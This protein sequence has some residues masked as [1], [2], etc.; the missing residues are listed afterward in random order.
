MVT[1]P[2]A[3][4]VS[5]PWRLTSPTPTSSLDQ[6]AVVPGIRSRPP[7]RFCANRFSCTGA[8]IFMTPSPGFITSAVMSLRIGGPFH[9]HWTVVAWYGDAS[10]AYSRHA[11]QETRRVPE[12][13]PSQVA[14]GQ[15]GDN[16]SNGGGAGEQRRPRLPCRRGGR[17]DVREA[18]TDFVVPSRPRQEKREE[19]QQEERDDQEEHEQTLVTWCTG[20]A[21][22]VGSGDD[23]VV[24]RG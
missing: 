15:V 18:G 13:G 19:K 23:R 7:L 3:R 6:V 21:A 2:G 22:W 12:C 17:G 4:G 24:Q 5:R 9:G 8:P 10:V 16:G 14:A 1:R 11:C 20:T